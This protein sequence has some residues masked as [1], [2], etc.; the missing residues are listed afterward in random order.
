MKA[1]YFSIKILVVLIILGTKPAPCAGIICLYD[2]T[3]IQIKTNLTAVVS[4]YKDFEIISEEGLSYADIE[5]PVND[6]IEF[7]GLKGHTE[8][9]NGK[10]LKIDKKNY[11]TLTGRH[12]REFG[13]KKAVLISLKSPTVGA[14]IHYEYRLYVE[15][16]LYLPKIA[17]D[18]YCPVKRMAVRIDWNRKIKPNF[19]YFGFK[20]TESENSAN[21]FAEDLPEIANEPYSCGD[22]LFLYISADELKFDK[23]K[24]NCESW[25]DVGIFFSE[26]AQQPGGTFVELEKLANKLLAPATNK[27]DSLKLLFEFVADSVS[28]VSLRIGSGDFK[29]HWCGEI[30]ERRFG[31]CKDQSILLS[32]L[33]RAVGIESYPALIAT[34]AYPHLNELYPWPSF[35]DHAIV[36]VPTANNT[37][38]LDPSD[39]YSS[40][41]DIPLRLRGK[42]Y[43]PIDGVSDLKLVPEDPE[44]SE[45]LTWRF[46]IEVDSGGGVVSGFSIAYANDA[47]ARN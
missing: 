21:F 9:P 27:T 33:Y 31:D 14:K 23:K 37:I 19:N 24:Y 6:Y 12:D 46:N 13:G 45:G 7:S 44:P 40:V 20:K 11:V 3:S 15:S 36:A 42:Y 28:Y 29:P 1:A 25:Q 5:V 43:L 41:D 2:S 4:Y 16:L 39:T 35:F 8:L 38:I 10:K 32:S 47:A 34:G 30:L 22:G 26:L 18:N 17:H